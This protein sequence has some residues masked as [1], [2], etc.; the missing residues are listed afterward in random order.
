MAGVG[1]FSENS[2]GE[3]LDR[4][5]TAG[6]QRCWVRLTRVCNNRCLFC[7]DSVLHDGSRLPVD[8]LRAEIHSGRRGGAERLILSGGEPTLHPSF[9]DLIA[10]G[11]TRGYSWIQAVSN[12]RM[13]AY[14]GFV[15]RC[16]AAGLDE[17]TLS[18]HGHTPALHDRL[19]G[20]PG[21]FAQSLLGLDQLLAAGLVVSVD[22]VLT[23]LNLPELPELIG[24][25]LERGVR[26]FDLLWLVPFGR[27]W[28]DRQRLFIPPDASLE[29]LR[30]A[31][32]TAR[33][34]GAVVWTNRLPP[35]MLEGNETLIQDPH[36]I[37]DEVRGRRPEL[38]AS[39]DAGQ[40][41][42]CFDPERCPQ[43]FM[44]GFCQSL[45]ALQQGLACG[46][47][48]CL[49]LEPVRGR[50]L[51][52]GLKIERL[53]LSTDDPPAAA[54]WV[55][56]LENPPDGVVLELDWGQSPA[57]KELES[58]DELDWGR[59]TRLLRVASRHPGCLEVLLDQLDQ[60]GL[61]LEIV[62][63]AASAEWIARRAERLRRQFDRLSVSLRCFDSLRQTAAE[64]VE[65]AAALAPLGDT[66]IELGDL[67]HCAL[68]AGRP[69]T[70]DPC[71]LAAVLDATGAIDLQRF[72]EAYICAG[73]RVWSAA[74]ATCPRRVDCPGMPIQ[75]TRLFGLGRLQPPGTQTALPGA[76]HVDSK[77]EI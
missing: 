75:H 44:E 12:G 42:P 41:M 57:P 35:R 40:P 3:L 47:L 52:A 33:D 39:L 70:V 50:S 11:R 30:R 32:V 38:Q 34:R 13:F 60:P 58:P 14:P 4:E 61:A 56:A 2:A 16:L 45:Q 66:P 53:R 29:P 72:T 22:V 65:P 46:R 77:P 69:Q 73:Y 27:A 48:A 68:A 63:D 59:R 64:G 5:Q 55:R 28:Q 36:K 21:A 74:C 15:Q 49:A 37:H 67:P 24:F 54:A 6:E 25:Y 10:Y 76:D 62:L 19:V 9:I 26:E 31:M 43:C 17:V 20:V 71:P 7:H 1:G 51:P 18:L 23:A 8:Q